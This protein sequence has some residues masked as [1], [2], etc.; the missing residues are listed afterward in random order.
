MATRRRQLGGVDRLPSGRYRVRLTD[1]AT[2]TEV[3][4]G[5][6][7]SK[8]DAE[9]ALASAVAAQDRGTWKGGP[10]RDAVWQHQWDIARRSVGLPDLHFPD[11]SHVAAMPTAATG[12]SV[13]EIMHRLGHSSAQAAATSTPCRSETGPSPRPFRS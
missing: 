2:G 11:P 1:P 9:K 10:L 7:T 3:S 12:A 8:A 13:K 6:Y 4:A 5:T